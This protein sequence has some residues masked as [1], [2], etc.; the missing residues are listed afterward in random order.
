M[1]QVTYL[2]AGAVDTK[3]E[4]GPQATPAGNNPST[5]AGVIVVGALVVLL[6]ARRSFSR[7]L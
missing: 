2:Q 6:V 7:Y 1:D 3:A 4:G 5:W